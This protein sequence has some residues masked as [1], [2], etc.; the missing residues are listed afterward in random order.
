VFWYG[1]DGADEIVMCRN[2]AMSIPV[3]VEAGASLRTNSAERL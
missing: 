3:T 1:I 2:H